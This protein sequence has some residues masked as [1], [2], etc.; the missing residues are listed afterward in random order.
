MYRETFALA[1]EGSRLDDGALIFRGSVESAA[2][3]CGAWF[4]ELGHDKQ[5]QL[6]E[7]RLDYDHHSPFYGP[8]GLLISSDCL[9]FSTSRMYLPFG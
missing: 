7:F 9:R 5:R 8:S 1:M 4:P 3:A 6:K 2:G